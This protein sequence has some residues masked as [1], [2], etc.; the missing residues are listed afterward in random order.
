M[1]TCQAAQTKTQRQYFSNLQKISDEVV[2]SFGVGARYFIQWAP[3]TD[4]VDLRDI[5]D[6]E[7]AKQ[8]KIIVRYETAKQSK[9]IVRYNKSYDPF[10]T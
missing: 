10:K 1:L 7:T 9:I 6:E 5:T 4:T 8:S 3:L 2:G